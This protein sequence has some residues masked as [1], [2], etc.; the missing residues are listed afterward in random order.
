[1]TTK[2]T[3]SPTKRQRP[4]ESVHSVRRIAAIER[5]VKALEYRKMG[6]NYAQIATKLEMAS[7]QVAWNTVN[8]ALRRMLQE[9][10]DSVRRIELE[11]LDAMFVVPYGNALRG[12]MQAIDTCL[13]LMQRRAKLLGID[14]PEKKELT[15][16][17]GAPLDLT[18]TVIIIGDSLTVIPAA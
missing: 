8:S 7:H 2:I 18:P 1:M 15:G 6:L 3:R 11:R 10:A 17:D 5:Q 4:G 13:K 16:A 9:P 12:D 14:A